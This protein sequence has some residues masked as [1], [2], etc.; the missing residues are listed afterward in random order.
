MTTPDYDWERYGF[1]VN[2]GPAVLKRNG[3]VFV[4]FSASDTGIH[5][6]VG[7]LTADESSDL[8]DPRSWERIVIRCFALMRQQEFTDPDTIRLP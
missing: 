1:W 5:Y 3:K 7:L 6:C 2:E 8:L 4:T